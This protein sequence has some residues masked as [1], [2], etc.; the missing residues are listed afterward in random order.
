MKRFLVILLLLP[1][2]VTLAVAQKMGVKIINRQSSEMTY[3][4][5]VPGFCNQHTTGNANCYGSASSV[6][7]SGTNH[8]AG[9]STPARAGS[10]SVSGATFSLALPD[11]RVAVV[12]CDS[13]GWGNHHRRSCRTPLVDNIMAD[14]KGDDA[15]LIWPVSLDG[16]KL[17][18]ETYKILAVLDKKEKA[19]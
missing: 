5:V 6:N 14:F 19:Q 9:F 7:C 11:G 10:Y 16:K 17:E 1:F 2:C 12:N 13:K 18:S 15:K 4:Y 3:N 8:T